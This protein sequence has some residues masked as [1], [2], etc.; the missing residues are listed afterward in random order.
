MLKCECVSF[1]SHQLRV[2]HRSLRF[3]AAELRRVFIPFWLPG[4]STL[5]D[6]NLS[7]GFS[8]R[9]GNTVGWHLAQTRVYV[10]PAGRFGLCQT[11]PRGGRRN[12]GRRGVCVSRVPLEQFLAIIVPHSKFLAH[13]R[14]FAWAHTVHRWV[15]IQNL[16]QV[17]APF[18]QYLYGI[19]F[20]RECF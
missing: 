19:V 18:S 6:T 1:S 12:S 7:R 11:G 17:R 16:G 9:I 15:G 20:P 2:A 10:Y 4:S 14:H 8:N 13:A 3:Q 5:V